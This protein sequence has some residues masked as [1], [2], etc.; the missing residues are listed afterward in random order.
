MILSFTFLAKRTVQ[1]FVIMLSN[2][3]ENLRASRPN[4]VSHCLYVDHS[5]KGKIGAGGSG[6][7]CSVMCEKIV[8]LS[9]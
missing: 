3:E 8:D 9:I 7:V 6:Q 4:I 5:P 1:L 2:A